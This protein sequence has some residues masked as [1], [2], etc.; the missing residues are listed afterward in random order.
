MAEFPP[1]LLL[2]S[3][4]FPRGVGLGRGLIPSRSAAFESPGPKSENMLSYSPLQ[5]TCSGLQVM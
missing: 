4:F 3:L 1:L 5:I 2:A